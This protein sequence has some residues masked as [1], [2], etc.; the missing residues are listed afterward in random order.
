MNRLYFTLRAMRAI[1]I[2]C[3]LVFV[4]ACSNGDNWSGLISDEPVP[5]PPLDCDPL[6]PT[7]CGFPYPNNYW[8]E[9][10]PAAVTGMQ[11]ALPQVIMPTNINGLQSNPDA[12][13][14]MDGFSPGV[15][16]MTHLP[17]ATVAG[18]ATPDSIA[19]SLLANS[20][21]VIINADTGE[22]LAHCVDLD[23]YVVQ[24]KLREDA[25]EDLPDFGIERDIEAL[26]QEQAFML[27]P[28]IRPE[29]ATR[30]IVA[31]MLMA[32]EIKLMC[33]GDDLD[34]ACR[35]DDGARL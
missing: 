7:Y 15:A 22:R 4:A 34:G 26:R 30:Y 17:G 3:V 20:P 6:T 27:R 19:D 21:T 23:E 10:D 13:N 8:T 33:E 1:S 35:R 14:E 28:A 5:A 9:E 11:L 24:A 25:A 29:D 12:F 31:A 32:G 2:A 16:A 18:L